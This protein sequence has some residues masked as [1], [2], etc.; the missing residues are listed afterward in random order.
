MP[1]SVSVC[2]R[3]A[4]PPHSAISSLHTV[5]QVP[6][7]IVNLTVS[8]LPASLHT[9]GPSQSLAYT[10]QVSTDTTTFL[11]AKDERDPYCR[12]RDMY[13]NPRRSNHR[14]MAG[15]RTSGA[16]QRSSG[17]VR[18]KCD[19]AEMNKLLSQLTEVS[20]SLQ[21]TKEECDMIAKRCPPKAIAKERTQMQDSN[22]SYREEVDVGVHVKEEDAV[23]M[24]V[25]REEE[26]THCGH[27][28]EKTA[29]DRKVEEL[30]HLAHSITQGI[31]VEQHHNIIAEGK[32]VCVYMTC[33]RKQAVCG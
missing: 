8:P 4:D 17:F 27:G 5:L 2:I 31:A 22:D 20:L 6:A 1:S 14:S 33:V 32:I 25:L 12:Y 7:H 18:Q 21:R 29:A 11:Q 23:V 15:Q 24:E 30:I 26:R 16:S 13:Q 10:T 19:F 9:A 28:V 3:F